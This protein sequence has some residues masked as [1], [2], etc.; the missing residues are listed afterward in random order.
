MNK[1]NYEVWWMQG[2]ILRLNKLPWSHFAIFYFYYYYLFI[3][4]LP[5]LVEKSLYPF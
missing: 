5:L 1:L 3:F 4:W 2:S